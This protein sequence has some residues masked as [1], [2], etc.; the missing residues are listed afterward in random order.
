MKSKLFY[1]KKNKQL[2]KTILNFLISQQNNS[3]F[4]HNMQNPRTVGDTVQDVLCD[5]MKNI[6]GIYAVDY[7]KNFTR[8]DMADFAFRDKDDLYY[9][10]DVKTHRLNSDFNMPNLTSIKKLIELYKNDKNY[11]ILLKIDYIMKKNKI[12]FINVYFIPVEFIKLSCL[13]IGALGWGQLQ[14]AN[15]NNI[16]ILKPSS[17]KEWMIELCDKILAFYPDEIKKIKKRLNYFKNIKN[18]WQNV[19]N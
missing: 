10:V 8:R 12:N 19:S 11:F 15:A 5:N 2:E 4:T 13:T 16:V 18:Q 17:R 1:S 7:S 3:I 9:V 6:L 14:I